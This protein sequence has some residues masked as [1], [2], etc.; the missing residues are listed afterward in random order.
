MNHEEISK[1]HKLVQKRRKGF[2]K[3]IMRQM[4]EEIKKTIALRNKEFFIFIIYS[5]SSSSFT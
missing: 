2:E 5:F 1:I 4:K 3:D